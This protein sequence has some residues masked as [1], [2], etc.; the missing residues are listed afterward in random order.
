MKVGAEK[1]PVEASVCSS[2][3]ITLKEAY[4][5][6]VNNEAH[7]VNEGHRGSMNNVNVHEHQNMQLKYIRRIITKD[8]AHGQRVELELCNDK[9]IPLVKPFSGLSISSI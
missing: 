8:R 3:F 7:H 6:K 4:C 2:Q 1:L 9:F 5:E